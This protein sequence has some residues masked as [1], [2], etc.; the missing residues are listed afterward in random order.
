MSEKMVDASGVITSMSGKMVDASGVITS[1]F[2]MLKEDTYVLI[3]IESL[4]ALVTMMFLVMFI[5]DFYRCRSRNS[6]VITV[7][8]TIDSL[9][10]QIVMYLLGAMQSARF[11]NQMFPVWC[12]VLVSLRAS[13]GYLSGYGITDRER[14]LTEVANVIKFLAFGVLNGTRGLEFHKPLWVLWAILLLRSVYRFLAHHWAIGSLWHGRSSE[15][16]PA[17]MHESRSDRE[18][19]NN[20]D[21][22]QTYLIY[23]ESSQEIGLKRPGYNLH[24]NIVD[25]PS[26]ITLD[27]ISECREPLLSSSSSNRYKDMGLAFTLS[28]LL[29]CRLEDVTLHKETKKEIQRLI[30]SEITGNQQMEVKRAFK[31]L[32]LELAFVRDY[33][34][35][36]YPMV[37]WRGLSSLCFS[38]LL[39]I[40]TFSVAFWLA[41]GI[42]KAYEP[43]EGTL[44]VWVGRWNVD[45]LITWVFMFFMMFKEVWEIV[46]YLLSNWTRLLLVCKY[47]QKSQSWLMRN[48]LTEDLISSFFVSKIAD[49]WH[50]RIDQYDFLQSCTYKP[51]FW[52]IANAV[53]LGKTERKLDGRNRGKAIKI[54]ECVKVAILQAL[55][56]IGL[57]NRQLPREIPSLNDLNQFPRYKWA[58]LDLDTC[59]QVILVWHIATSLCEI[60]LAQECEM[61]LTKPRFLHS[62]WS[63]LKT[64]FCCTSKPYLVNDNIHMHGDLK[65]CYHTATSLSRYCAYLQ[66]FRPELLPD[67]FVVPDL[68]FLEALQ[69]ARE[70]PDDCNLIWCWYNKLMVIA[71]EAAQKKQEA[72]E[73]NQDAAQDYVDR[74]LSMNLVQQG[75]TLGKDLIS[76]DREIR[77]K[78]LAGVWADLLVHIA[79]S[80]NAVDHKNNL[81]SGGEFITLIWA[82]LCH[83]GIEKSKMWDKE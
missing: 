82:L 38:I 73:N 65:T 64:F 26:L 1:F 2:I 19:G 7:L 28:R 41:I 56:R 81:E 20:L 11:D 68:I 16:L 78:I 10:D 36:L 80:W 37:F 77:W 33:F 25:S 70:R 79:P 40:A 48:A 21:K 51:S 83:C 66:V 55:S 54:P 9:S 72:V 62:A 29:R 47:V 59:S 12:T 43:L 53:T 31:I 46:T 14:R 5:M 76:M 52:K 17:Y 30:I 67:S 50:G 8:K 35:T 60:K 75:A 24:L 69:K 74:R 61:D 34:Y 42:R 13:L 39:S 58:C 57:N 23:G 15:F 71:E 4:V 27:R 49:P 6:T 63:R 3:R 44:V 45:V 22:H 18:E 32:E